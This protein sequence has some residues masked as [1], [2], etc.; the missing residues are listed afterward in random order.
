[1]SD[2]KNAGSNHPVSKG[3]AARGRA[4][5]R[6]NQKADSHTVGSRRVAS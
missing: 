5:N 2:V 1:M 3:T 4:R 6:G